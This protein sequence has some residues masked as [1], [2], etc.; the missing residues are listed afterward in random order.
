MIGIGSNCSALRIVVVAAI[1]TDDDW[2]DIAYSIGVIEGFT[3]AINLLGSRH[4]TNSFAIIIAK[5]FVN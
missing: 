3:M 2:I 1:T 5:V 4:A